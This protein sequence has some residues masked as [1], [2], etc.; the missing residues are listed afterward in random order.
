MGGVVAWERWSGAA[1]ALREAVGGSDGA[2]GGIW[3]ERPLGRRRRWGRRGRRGQRVS[4]GA[5]GGRRGPWEAAAGGGRVRGRCAAVGA[6]GSSA[7]RGGWWGPAGTV[8]D[9]DRRLRGGGRAVMAAA[10]V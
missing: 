1:V 9:I 3:G 5:V 2:P 10:T 8:G 4:R 6:D 7:R